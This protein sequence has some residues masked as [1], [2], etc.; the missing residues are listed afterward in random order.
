MCAK[1]IYCA[2][3]MELKVAFHGIASFTFLFGMY[4]DL[5]CVNL[6]EPYKSMLESSGALLKGRTAFLT[7]L[8]LVSVCNKILIWRRG[9][10]ARELSSW[11]PLPIVL[12]DFRLLGILHTLCYVWFLK[13]NN[14]KFRKYNRNKREFE[15]CYHTT[16]Q[17]W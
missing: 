8:N 6:P 17:T 16:I 15:T 2:E 7:F 12:L 14:Q 1:D 4:Y 10:W 9:L 11:M 13:A 5:N 3:N